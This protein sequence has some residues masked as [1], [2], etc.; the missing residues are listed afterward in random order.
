M[1]ARKHGHVLVSPQKFQNSFIY[2]NKCSLGLKTVVL[3]FAKHCFGYS[4]RKVRIRGKKTQ[5]TIF[6]FVTQSRMWTV[7]LALIGKPFID[8]QGFISVVCWL[9]VLLIFRLTLLL[10]LLI[11]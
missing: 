2:N 1:R 5:S 7:A 11:C 8:F 3:D 10:F 4:K 9:L 6:C